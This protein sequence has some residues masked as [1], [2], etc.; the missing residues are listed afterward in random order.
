MAP[1]GGKAN[2]FDH[3]GRAVH[4]RSIPSNSSWR[5]LGAEQPVRHVVPVLLGNA[6]HTYT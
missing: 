4:E 3:R 2:E 6:G 1:V 5:S